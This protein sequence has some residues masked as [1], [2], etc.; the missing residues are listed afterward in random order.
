MSYRSHIVMALIAVATCLVSANSA[1]AS[2]IVK[3][4][5]FVQLYDTPNRVS[6][7]GEFLYKRNVVD[8]NWNSS[9]LDSAR[10]FCCEM[11]EYMNFN[12]TYKVASVGTTTVATNKTLTAGVASLYRQWYDGMVSNQSSATFAGASYSYSNATQRGR[13]G[14]ALQIAIWNGMGFDTTSVLNSESSDIKAKA[15]TWISYISS[16][17]SSSNS[18]SDLFGVRIMNLKTLNGANAQDQ[19][20][21]VPEPGLLGAV[22]CV[23]AGAGAFARRKRSR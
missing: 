14:R 4:G 15:T 13:D 21:A 1:E 23:V 9:S 11:T 17:N 20:T 8:S 6:N 10:T 12:T 22:L 7:G 3:A 16:M 18:S 5:D 19:L 2:F